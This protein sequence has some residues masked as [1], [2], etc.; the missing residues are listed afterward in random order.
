MAKGQPSWYKRRSYLHFDQPIKCS[1]AQS[2]VMSPHRVA[3][4]AFFPLISYTISSLKVFRNSLGELEKKTK[5]RPIAFASH[6]DSH[7]YSYYTQILSKLYELSIEKYGLGKNVLAFRSLGKNNIHFANQA[8]EKIKDRGECSVVAMDI[9]GFFQNLEHRHLKSAWKEL[10]GEKKIPDDHFNL[11]KSLTRYSQVDQTKLYNTLGIAKN[12]PRKARFKVCDAVTFREKVRRKGLITVNDS[13]AGIPQGTP[14]SAL[15]SNIYMLD[16]DKRIKQ[17]VEERSGEY[18]RYCDDMLFIVPHEH[19]NDI[20]DF[21]V[22]ELS[23]LGLDIN[24]DKTEVRRFS[25]HGNLQISDRPLQYLGFTFDGQRKLIRSSALAR[26]SGKMKAG[27]RQAKKK[28]NKE[29]LLKSE[30]GIQT[31]PLFRKKLY[32]RYSHLGR[33][34]FITYGHDA[35]NHM[36]SSA[37]RRQLKPLWSRLQREFN[38]D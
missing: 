1:K 12:N 22:K 20:Q 6:V 16:F 30:N 32:E 18:F 35:A 14:I 38:S 5:Q 4:H 28:Q 2:L 34:N 33:R 27:V 37:I 11:F 8:F 36:E 26:F 23:K 10:L 9:S 25:M 7:I 21:A 15:L 13:G 31:K 17:V 29:N 3:K 19:Q 24:P